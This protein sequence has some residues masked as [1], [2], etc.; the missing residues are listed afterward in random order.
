MVARISYTLPTTIVV[1]GQSRE[2]ADRL[3][4][5]CR[6]AGH[7]GNSLGV[8]NEESEDPSGHLRVRAAATAV[9]RILEGISGL[10]LDLR[11]RKSWADF[12]TH[13]SR[14]GQMTL[15]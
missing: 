11:V 6:L 13:V 2:E 5:A 15:R 7:N 9:A 12:A 1:M 10:R 14:F 3:F 8:K 4:T